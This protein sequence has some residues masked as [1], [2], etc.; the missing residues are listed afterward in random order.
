M[1]NCSTTII[2]I[3]KSS[4]LHYKLYDVTNDNTLWLGNDT[5]QLGELLTTIVEQYAVQWEELG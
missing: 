4:K 1:E 3:E 2:P 5:P